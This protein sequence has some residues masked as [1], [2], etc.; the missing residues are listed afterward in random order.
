MIGHRSPISGVDTFE[1]RLVATAGYD[2]QLILWD[3]ARKRPLA[4][5]CHDHLA[6]QCRFSP[7]GRYL[8]SASSDYTARVW[9]VPDM[10]LLSVLNSHE[11]DVEMATFDEGS[12]RIA[13]ASRDASV[14]LFSRNGRVLQRL[15][16]HEADV[17]SVEW[18]STSELVSTSDDGTV[19]RWDADQGRLLRT[20]DFGS[21][22]TDT[23][24]VERET[25]QLCVGNDRGEIIVISDSSVRTVDAH[26]AGIKRVVAGPSRLILTTSYDRTAKLWR[27][28]PDGVLELL[29]EIE[30]PAEVWPRSAVFAGPEQLVFGTFGTTYATYHIADGRWDLSGFG[31]TGGINGLYVA[32]DVYTVGDAGVVRRGGETVGE[33]GAL[34]NFVIGAAGRILTGGQ[35]GQLLDVTTGDV[36]Y[37]HRS[38]LNCACTFMAGDAS[39]LLVGSYTGE[40]LLFDASDPALRHLATV[41]LHDNAVKGVAVSATHAFSVCA[42][43]AAAF[44]ALPDLS[45]VLQVPRAHHKIANGV[46]VLPD[47]RFASVGRDLMLRI[48]SL[49]G[50][51]AV[52]TPHEHSV[53][54]VASSPGTMLV[55]TG[56][57]DGT[58]AVYDAARDEWLATDRPTTSGIS[59]LAAGTTPGTFVAGSYDGHLYTVVAR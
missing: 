42:T 54:C 13:T 48:W 57:F 56:A 17:L 41:S 45:P 9:S 39:R 29:S 31:P 49:G 46:T 53:K 30:L 21:V 5:G 35:T 7:C 34:C 11:D 59:S 2:N 22:E 27:A 47:G 58:V 51:T 15:R 26:G 1:D 14:R 18:L 19:S 55:A 38:P 12:E 43:G 28:Q 16:G 8:V 4:R 36:L 32:G 52:R 3:G 37:Q 50:S 25:G 24:A 6:N 44:H 23:L 33:V 20:Y 10:R 40:G